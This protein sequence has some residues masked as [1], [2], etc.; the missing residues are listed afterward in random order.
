MQDKTY[1]SR[2]ILLKCIYLWGI[3]WESTPWCPSSSVVQFSELSAHENMRLFHL[4][5]CDTILHMI[6]C[7]CVCVCVCLCTCMLSRS[8]ISNSLLPYG[9]YVACQAPLSRGFSRQEHWSGLPCPFRGEP[10]WP[11]DQI[12]H[13]LYLLHWRAGPLPLPPS[14]RGDENCY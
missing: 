6:V 5:G 1:L 4:K 13:L 10:S 8:V 2:E 11:R 14:G 7:V 9:L 12:L 3:S